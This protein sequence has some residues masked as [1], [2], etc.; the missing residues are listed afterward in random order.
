[1]K[2]RIMLGLSVFKN[3][4]DAGNTLLPFWCVLHL[5]YDVVIGILTEAEPSEMPEDFVRILEDL[6]RAGATIYLWHKGATRKLMQDL[7]GRLAKPCWLHAS[8]GELPNMLRIIA[9]RA[10]CEI[11][12]RVDPTVLALIDPFAFV[13]RAVSEWLSGNL[14]TTSADYSDRHGP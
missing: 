11:L 10:G 13:N 8:Y 12:F 3:W 5:N 14:L 9:H 7:P 2:K 6:K 4:I 1:M